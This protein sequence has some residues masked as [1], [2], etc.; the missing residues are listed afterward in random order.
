[1]NGNGD[2]HDTRLSRIEGIVEAVAINQRQF[3][4]AQV[5][6][7]EQVEKTQK[8]VEV[9]QKQIQET[10]RRLGMRIDQVDGQ[11]EALVKIVDG[12]IRG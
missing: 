10:D 3:P 6:L 1:M 8:Q 12:M 5:L 4:T 9:T 7:T 2:N 11:I